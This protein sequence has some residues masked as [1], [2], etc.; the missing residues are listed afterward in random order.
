MT[1]LLLSSVVALSLMVTSSVAKEASTPG[2]NLK[3]PENIM[4]PDKV[5]SRIGELTFF[6]GVPTGDTVQKVYD[7]LDYVRG[8]DT[9]LKFIPA[10]N[11]EGMRTGTASLGVSNTMKC[12][13]WIN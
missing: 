12:Y 1:K 10:C 5:N 11:I 8:I 3:I 4:T 9:F 13:S 2:F 7:N 6:D